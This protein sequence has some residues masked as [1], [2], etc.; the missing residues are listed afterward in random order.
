VSDRAIV[1]L[2]RSVAALGAGLAI[3]SLVLAIAAGDVGFWSQSFAGLN[4]AVALSFA[5]IVWLV[6][7]RQPRNATVWAMSASAGNGVLAATLSLVPFSTEQ[8]L[9]VLHHE[10]VPSELGGVTGWL[11]AVGNAASVPG[12]FVP[13]TVGLIVF[14]DGRFPS[15]RWRRIAALSM[16]AIAVLAITHGWWYRPTN[17]SRQEEPLTILSG[18]ACV[19]LTVICVVGLFARFRR[20][21]G[22]AR[23]QYKW[24]AFGTAMGALVFGGFFFLPDSA[25]DEPAAALV[26]TAG[27][28]C[29]VVSYGVAVA[30]YRLYEVDVVISR[31]VV[32]LSL[33]A[34]ITAI[35]VVVV[36]VIGDLVGGSSVWLSVAATALVA[37]AFEPARSRL[38]RWA[39]RLVHGSRAT[40]YEILAEVTRRLAAVERSE[41]LLSRLADRLRAGSGAQ[42]VTVWLQDGVLRPIVAAPAGEPLP[43]PVDMAAALPGHDFPIDHH[44]EI[45]GHLT[46]EEQP[47]SALR[48]NDSRLAEDL[49]GSAALVVRKLRLD[50]DLETTAAEIAESRRRLLD[51]EDEERR[52]LERELNS[53]V[54]Q[55][56]VALKVQLGLAARTALDEGSERAA[57]L[58]AGL[59]SDAGDAIEQIRSLARGIY[60]PLLDSDG[61]RA[62]LPE[63][64]ARA[65]LEVDVQVDADR[66]EPT[67]EGAVYFCVA[68][69]LTN[70]VKHA[71]GQVAVSVENTGGVLTFA[72][73]DSGP[74]FDVE[75]TTPG[76]GLHNMQ[77][78]LDALG[79]ELHVTSRPGSATS[80]TGRLPL[81]VDAA[82]NAGLAT[83]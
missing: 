62:A 70:A 48:P 78:R 6:V 77:D 12:L 13:L 54:E 46:V 34:L 26:G 61:L 59:E 5:P 58:I 52:R 36:V 16:V 82:V 72:V 27:A 67:V 7:K 4:A 9:D 2:L 32:Y 69:A 66:Y 51:A 39:N 30:R 11:L 71:R 15:A 74:G 60:P 79:G 75:R 80:I 17:D 81:T 49:A 1:G 44:G 55:Q 31:S 10:W 57:T 43:N 22:T 65:P 83:T 35:Y 50:R 23:L 14:P 63:L 42:R 45:L 18:T 76:S 25:Y 8:P 3:V 64:A 29:W 19:L 37:L 33:A 38:Q 73:R 56:V 41:E 21:T 20:S 40:P 68:E 28:V 24:I 53:G 47:G